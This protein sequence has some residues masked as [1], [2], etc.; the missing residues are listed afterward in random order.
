MARNKKMQTGG[1]VL[2]PGVTPGATGV[3]QAQPTMQQR[4]VAASTSQMSN[5]KM[6]PGM[7]KGGIMLEE[8]GMLQEGGTIDPAS[9][10]EVPTGSLQEEVRDDIPAQLSEGEFV[11]PADV[12]RFI[13]LER[14]MQMRQAAK[15]GL[16]QMDK[17]GQM[18]NA[19][20]AT[21]DD[22]ADIEFESEIDDILAEVEAEAQQGMA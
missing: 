14:L 9:G 18:G 1:V 11:F 8:G 16:A 6:P 4:E 17:M 3:Q 19:D 12:V 10:N 2:Q 15:K 13:G 21:M 7:A 5:I 20:E 22:G